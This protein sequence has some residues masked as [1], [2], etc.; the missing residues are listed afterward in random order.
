MKWAQT[1]ERPRYDR[2]PWEFA[3]VAQTLYE[4]GK[5]VPGAIGLGFAVGTEPLP[6]LF[7]S[8]GVRVVATDLDSSAATSKIWRRTQQHGDSRDALLH[9]NLVDRETFERQ[10]EFAFADMNGAW[11]WEPGSFDFVWSCCAFEHTGSLERGIDFV[12]RSS[13]LLKPGG[14]GV[15]TTEFNCSSNEKTVSRGPGVIYRQR[16]IEALDHRLRRE[17]RALA[18]PD[19]W[20][21]DDEHDRIYDTPPYFTSGKQHVKLEIDG[22]VSTSMLVTV[23][24]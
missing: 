22:Y 20:P 11:P 1:P 23:V 13:R 17:G 5:L 4:R 10:V 6:S 3:A 14:L 15:H 16:D 24:N 8:L 2:K 9:E 7:A 18:K 21:G 12:L 19:F